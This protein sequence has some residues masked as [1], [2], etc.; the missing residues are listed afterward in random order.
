MCWKPL[1][2]SP[3]S[4]SSSSAVAAI[5]ELHPPSSLSSSPAPV[6]GAPGLSS[7]QFPQL[8]ESDFNGRRPQDLRMDELLKNNVLAAHAILVGSGS[9]KQLGTAQILDRVRILSGTSDFSCH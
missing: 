5:S 4:A 2:L 6:S 7:D 1:Y 9:G 3:L 8:D